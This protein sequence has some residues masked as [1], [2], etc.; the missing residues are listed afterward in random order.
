ML[1]NELKDVMDRGVK[2]LGNVLSS[3]TRMYYK[4]TVMVLLNDCNS[5]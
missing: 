4:A 1:G 2:Q 5:D 3:S